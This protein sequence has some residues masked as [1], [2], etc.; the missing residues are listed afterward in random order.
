[1]ESSSRESRTTSAAY[2]PASTITAR[3]PNSAAISAPG[4]T[5]A[6]SS[7]TTSKS[8][9][10]SSCQVPAPTEPNTATARIRSSLA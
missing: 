9:S 5:R 3:G 10:D 4:S 8:T 1:M 7:V 2:V 6:P